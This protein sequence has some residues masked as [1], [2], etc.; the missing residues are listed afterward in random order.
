MLRYVTLNTGDRPPYEHAAGAALV[1]HAR[2]CYVHGAW[3]FKDPHRVLR[4][5]STAL[6]APPAA[7]E[8]A[9]QGGNL[10][11]I[12]VSAGDRFISLHHLFREFL[13]AHLAHELRL[14]E[15]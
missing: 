2:T 10:P 4:N 11:T 3:S 15:A 6:T 9:C 8:A 14:V 5:S 12:G 7:N 1:A 13:L